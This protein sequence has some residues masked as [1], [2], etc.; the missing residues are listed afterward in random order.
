MERYNQIV[1]GVRDVIN[2]LYASGEDPLRTKSGRAKMMAAMRQ[3]NP[4][5][6]ANMR[7]NAK[8]GFEYLKNIEEAKAKD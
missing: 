3:I 6:I 1:G 7:T 2:N 5:E 8:L 4:G